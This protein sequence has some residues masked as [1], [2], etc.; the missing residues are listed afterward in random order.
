MR[1]ADISFLQSLLKSVVPSHTP[2]RISITLAQKYISI[3]TKEMSSSIEQFRTRVI[4][5]L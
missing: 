2:F 3:L 5:Y 1:L 4:Q